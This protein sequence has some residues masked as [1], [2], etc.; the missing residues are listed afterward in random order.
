MRVPGLV[1]SPLVTPRSVCHEILDHTSI[2]QFLAEKFTPGRP[3]SAAV[4]VRRRSGIASVSDALDRTAPRQEIP[5]AP[6]FAIAVTVPLGENRAPVTPLEATFEQAAFDMVSKFP[7]PTAQKY[8]EVSHWVL[9]QQDR[10]H[11]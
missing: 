8:P 10:P 9:S 1:V 4:D 2:L 11:A 7:K 6:D 3:Y 5:I